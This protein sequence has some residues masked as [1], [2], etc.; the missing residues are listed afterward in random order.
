MARV[1]NP[2]TQ[3]AAQTTESIVSTTVGECTIYLRLNMV[4]IEIL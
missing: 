2:T 4:I 1:K 3:R